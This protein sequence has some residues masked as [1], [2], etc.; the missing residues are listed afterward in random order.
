MYSRS[1]S[2]FCVK[3]SSCRVGGCRKI[4]E[5]NVEKKIFEKSFDK[6]NFGKIIFEKSFTKKNFGKK[7]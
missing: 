5:K 1:V 6:K 2:S 4:L 3:L 7:F